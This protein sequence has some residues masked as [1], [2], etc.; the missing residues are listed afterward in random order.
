MPSY[1]W[2]LQCYPG[3]YLP[4]KTKKQLVTFITSIMEVSVHLL[5]FN[6]VFLHREKLPKAGLWNLEH[7]KVHVQLNSAGM[8]K[9]AIVIK[10]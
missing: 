4:K 10:Y 7:W 8:C 6:L 5:L 3:T 2:Q 1:L 9:I